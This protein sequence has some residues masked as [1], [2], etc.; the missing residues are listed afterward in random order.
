MSDVSIAT[1]VPRRNQSGNTDGCV[2][3]NFHPLAESSCGTNV[4]KSGKLHG[5]ID[6]E[7]IYVK[8][9][10]LVS[11]SVGQD[12]HQSC[13]Q[14]FLDKVM[15]VWTLGSNVICQLKLIEVRTGEEI[16][17]LCENTSLPM[18]SLSYLDFRFR[19]NKSKI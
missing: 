16:K 4:Q 9:F 8:L 18:A 10:C 15:M 3:W 19:L 6:R 17:V 2:Q 7:H 1:S 12:I 13:V 11:R 5:I 14:G